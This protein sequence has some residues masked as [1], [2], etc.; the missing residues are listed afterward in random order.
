M[1]GP[2]LIE[3]LPSFG[4]GLM[5]QELQILNDASDLL[6]VVFRPTLEGL[7]FGLH[8]SQPKVLIA[9]RLGPEF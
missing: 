6:R 2:R 9:V 4:G 1:E 5:G 3:L 8:L 7:Y